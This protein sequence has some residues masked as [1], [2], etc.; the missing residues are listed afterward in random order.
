M[1]KAIVTAASESFSQQLLALLGSLKANWPTHPPVIVYDLGLQDD[2]IE[3]LKERGV[4]IR[5]VPEFCPH[6]RKHF[7]WKIWC[8]N[9]IDS[10]TFLWMDA[11]LVVLQPLDELF[12]QIQSEGY[13]VFPNYRFLEEE[14]SEAACMGCGVDPSFRRSKSTLAGGLIGFNK[15]IDLILNILK[16]ALKLALVEENIKATDPKHRHDQALI[17]LLIYKNIGSPI[18]LDGRI[19]LGFHSPIL[20]P[21]QKVWVCRTSM[22]E[23]DIA[24]FS[25]Y[26][27]DDQTKFPSFPESP[28]KLIGNVIA[29]TERLL[30]RIYGVDNEYIEKFLLM[31]GLN[32]RGKFV[33]SN[34][35]KLRKFFQ[36]KWDDNQNTP[37]LINIYNGV[38]E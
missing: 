5:K 9:D 35:L 34:L 25:G 8:W 19:Y 18:I 27:L 2:L 12:H 29:D 17:S 23:L 6:W 14:A 33:F 11:G 10:E 16:T 1:K 24:N 20:V 3:T 31:R 7:T 28:P 22:T 4:Q 32:N 21:G 30:K 13:V 36:S 37:D 38:K 26:F 15:S